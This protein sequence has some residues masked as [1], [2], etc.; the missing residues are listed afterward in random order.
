MVTHLQI[1]AARAVGVTYRSRTRKLRCPPPGTRKFR[2]EFILKKILGLRAVPSIDLFTA[3][4]LGRGGQHRSRP[5]PGSV[6]CATATAKSAAEAAAAYAAAPR[7]TGAPC[8]N[9]HS[10]AMSA[11]FGRRALISCWAGG[12]PAAVR[13]ASTFTLLHN[14]ACRCEHALAAPFKTCCCCC[15]LGRPCLSCRYASATEHPAVPWR[16]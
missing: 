14:P 16:R 1:C 9:M 4:R 13:C 12:R 3:A 5:G 2:T 7:Y 10:A 8:V 11:A 6:A 15:H